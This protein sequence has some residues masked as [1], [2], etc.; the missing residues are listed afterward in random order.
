MNVNCLRIKCSSAS[1]SYFLAIWTPGYVRL[2]SLLASVSQY[3]KSVPDF[4]CA[5][6]EKRVVW[7]SSR[8]AANCCQLVTERLLLCGPQK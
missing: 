5:N 3:F 4:H 1:L 6:G 7:V 2:P 8:L